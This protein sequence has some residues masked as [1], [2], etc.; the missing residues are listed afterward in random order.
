MSR[1][2]W[3]SPTKCLETMDFFSHIKSK[4]YQESEKLLFDA[5]A[6]GA[7][8]GMLNNEVVPKAHI[9]IYLSL[10]SQDKGNP[11]GNVLPPDLALCYDDLCAV[12]D[13]PSIDNRKRGRPKREHSGWTEDRKLAFEMHKMMQKGKARSAA[14][15]A[16]IFV[17]AGL[18]SGA[19]TPESRAKRLERTF[20][21]HYSS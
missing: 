17:E 9:G 1:Y 12:F 10:Y 21:K 20:R 11:Q 16:R 18:V 3:I 7:I 15:A 13:R 2:R 14:H 5:V 8:K 19:G 6:S 4:S